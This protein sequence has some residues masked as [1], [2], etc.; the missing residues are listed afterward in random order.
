MSYH[1]DMGYNAA[2]FKLQGGDVTAF[3]GTV[4]FTGDV[5]FED[6]ASITGVDLPQAEYQETSGATSIAQ[7]KDDF[8]ALRDKLV[9][10]GLMKNK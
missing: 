10:A 1:E 4:V 8:N 2:N 9:N 6:S 7:L 5:I 3:D